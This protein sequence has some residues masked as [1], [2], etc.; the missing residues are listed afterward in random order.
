[1]QT[2]Y[3]IT[4]KYSIPSDGKTHSIEIYNKELQANYDYKT[5]PKLS[6]DAYLMAKLSDW[7]NL[8]LLPGTAKLYFDNNYLGNSF[9]KTDNMEDTLQ[10]NLGNDKSIISTRKFL[11]DKSKTNIINGEKVVIKTVEIN[12]RNTKKFGIKLN[13]LDQIPISNDKNIVI[14]LIDAG[15]ATLDP[16]TGK[17]EWNF[18]IKSKETKKLNFTYEIKYPSNVALSLQ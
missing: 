8:N 5:I 11:R 7:E 1:M 14:T 16:S 13:M 2:E 3:E 18:N 15:S 6:S 17:L 4:L 10:F 12:I 9:I